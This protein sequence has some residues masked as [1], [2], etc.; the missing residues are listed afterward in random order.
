MLTLFSD[1]GGRYCDGLSRRNFLSIGTLAIGGMTLPNLFQLKAMGAVTPR[2]KSVI[3]VCLGGG[4]SQLETY[5][6]KPDAPA[7]FRGEFSPIKSNVPG[8]EM[9]ELMPLQAKIA[10]K[11]AVVRSATWTEPE[12]QRAEVFTGY[13]KKAHRPSFGSIVNKLGRC[14]DPQ[15]PRFVS[16]SGEYDSEIQMYEDP[17]YVGSQYRAFIPTGPGLESMKLNDRMNLERMNNRRDLLSKLDDIRREIDT[18]GDMR[19]YD[20]YTGQAMAMIAS[21]KVRD[22]F[23]TTKEDEATQRRYGT[24]GTFKYYRADSHWNS[25]LF[26]QARRLA[27]A[28]VPY[29]SMQVGT[30]DHHC[31]PTAGSIFE[32]YRTLMPLYDH[33]ITT[34]ITDLQ[35]RGLDKD[36]CVVVWGEF[37][38]TP[39]I[40]EFGGRDHWPGAG[41]V[42]F[43]GGGLKMGQYIGKTDSHAAEPVT[44]GYGP[45]RVLA[46]LYHVLGIDPSITIPDRS[47]RPQFLLD[48]R[49]PIP[50]LV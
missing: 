47:G 14:D 3:M 10:D 40:N 44:R 30:W 45:Q 8:M 29:I 36:V 17:Q 7:E 19:G 43:A 39:R 23:D 25:K 18:T 1:R 31:S 5:D 34:L 50:E 32:S 24:G 22:A 49:D 20:Q 21:S 2:C 13:P 28:G 41:C 11:F 37:G 4:P 48:E 35:E 38:R 12:H 6:M 16:L 9:S 26:L 33:S 46:T 15:L 27:E 42:M